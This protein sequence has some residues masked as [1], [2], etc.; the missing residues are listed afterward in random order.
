MSLTK[1]SEPEITARLD[2]LPE[3]SQP[4]EEIQRTY[5]FADFVGAMAFVDRIAD[6][7]ERVQHH[8]DILI[9]YSRVTLSL[10]THDAGG[11]TEKDFEFAHAADRMATASGCK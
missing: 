2:V 4:G 1:L 9:R 8:P 11:I 3:W 7:A 6:E 10:S 5:R